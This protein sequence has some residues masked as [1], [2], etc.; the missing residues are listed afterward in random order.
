MRTRISFTVSTTERTQL[1]AIASGR[2]MP[3]K[4]VWR[5]RIVLLTAGG[6]GTHAIMA[7]TGREQDHGLAMAGA[8]RL[9]RRRG[10]PLG[11]VSAA[12][13]SCP[14]TRRHPDKRTFLTE[15]NLGDGSIAEIN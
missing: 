8:V 9:G 11:Q 15:A 10:A 6:L 14:E 2:N 13:V 7:A 12:E 1:E 4:H 3:Q 5:A